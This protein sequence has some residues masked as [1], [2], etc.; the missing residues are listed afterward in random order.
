M[1]LNQILMIVGLCLF[2]LG[3]GFSL[4]FFSYM[5]KGVGMTFLAFF[6]LTLI[7]GLGMGLGFLLMLLNFAAIRGGIL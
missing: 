6:Q 5:I 3:L 4:R 7:G 1:L 2:V